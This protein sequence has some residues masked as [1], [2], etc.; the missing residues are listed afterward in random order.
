MDIML[1]KVELHVHLDG[2]VRLST[3]QELSQLPMEEVQKNSTTSSECSSLEEYLKC[4]SLPISVMQTKENLTRI[5]QEL[6]EDL[7]KDHVIYA[8]V[9]FFP[10]AHTLQGLDADEV[11][12]AVIEG[13][14]KVEI[15]IGVIL[16]MMRNES[17]K[18]NV[19]IINLAKRFLNRG[20]VALDLAGDEASYP[21]KDFEELFRLA[22][23][24]DIPFTIH[25]GEAAD[26]KS[27]EDAIRFGAS[28]IGHGIHAIAKKQLIEELKQKH[29]LLE[30]CPTSNIQT[31]AVK[32]IDEHPFW[33]MYQAGVR[34]SINTDN[35]TVSYTNLEKE[36]QLLSQH[37]PVTYL[38]FCQMNEMAMEASFQPEE[39]K[40]E[41]YQIIENYKKQFRE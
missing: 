38:D 3:L 23:K 25:A 1:P 13:F 14:Q 12:E 26:E 8:E 35:R 22:K 34:I 9:R 28:R 16:C 40:Q 30:M 31:K 15:P 39:K 33:K 2:S 17:T 20:V 37:F 24:L 21:T 10:L 27:V 4:F 7:Q 11:V 18:R 36:Y 29:I 6:G 5:A 32:N 19:E 41:F